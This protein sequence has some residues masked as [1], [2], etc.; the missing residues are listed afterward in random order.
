[1]LILDRKSK[2]LFEGDSVTDH[3]RD[4][5]NLYSLSAYTK[6]IAEKFQKSEVECFNRAVGGDRTINVLERVAREF[7]EFHP[8]LFSLLIGVNDTWRRYDNNDPTS[9]A[10]FEKNL[11]NILETARRDK[12][13]IV[14]LEPFLLPTDPLKMVMR[15]DLDEKIDITRKLA[16]EYADEFIPLDGLFAE[17]TLKIK[18]ELLSED[19]V[20]PTDLAYEYIAKWWLER[21]SVKS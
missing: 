10:V 9:G 18:P 11:R 14:I 2:I 5:E 15:E 12:A 20:H 6:I 1:M 16:R 19:G 4:R 17:L 13:K 21:I 8:D 3:K 7:D